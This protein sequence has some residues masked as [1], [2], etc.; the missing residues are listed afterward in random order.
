VKTK[1]SLR[2]LNQREMTTSNNKLNISFECKKIFSQQPLHRVDQSAPSVQ[3]SGWYSLI[4]QTDL[5]NVQ[6]GFKVN[7]C[8]IFE[9]D[10]TTYEEPILQSNVPKQHLFLLR[11]SE[12]KTGYHVHLNS[13]KKG[14]AR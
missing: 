8:V 13:Q 11:L 4:Q 6:S 7:D 2:V 10:I 3:N 9:A 14:A 12:T 1:F 5:R